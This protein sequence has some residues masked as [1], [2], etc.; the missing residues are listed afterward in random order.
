MVQTSMTQN[1]CQNKNIN[2]WIMIET[3]EFWLKPNHLTGHPTA[4]QKMKKDVKNITAVIATRSL[5]AFWT[6]RHERMCGKPTTSFSVDHLP[7][8]SVIA[9]GK[10]DH[11]SKVEFSYRCFICGQTFRTRRKLHI[12]AKLPY[13]QTERGVRVTG[14]PMKQ[15]FFTFGQGSKLDEVYEAN[16]SLISQNRQPDNIQSV[17]NISINN[18]FLITV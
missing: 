9:S 16:R 8:E 12:Y 1:L 2:T 14:S 18:Q 6:R 15:R 17:C 7:P 13:S 3:S 4:Q 10:G 11:S 5:C